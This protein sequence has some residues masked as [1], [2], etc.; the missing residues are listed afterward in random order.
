MTSWNIVYF[1]HIYMWWMVCWLL[2]ISWLLFLGLLPSPVVAWSCVVNVYIT[3]IKQL[4]LFWKWLYLD[5]KGQGQHV[6]SLS[7]HNNSIALCQGQWPP[8]GHS[9]YLDNVL[10][11][12][13]NKFIVPIMLSNSLS[14]SVLD[15]I[16]SLVMPK[17]IVSLNL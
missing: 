1:A 12:L 17:K 8:S 7:L 4:P 3:C 16:S 11:R 5:G 13:C 15:T 9:V 2:C 6:H 10:Y 14:K